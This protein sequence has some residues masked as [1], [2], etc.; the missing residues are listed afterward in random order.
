MLSEKKLIIK[1]LNNDS[2]AQK[3]LY[4]RYAPKMWGV[5]L[6]FAKNSMI[7]EDLLQEGFIKVYS[8]L[9]QYTHEGSFEG[10][11]RRT[12]INTAINYFKKNI[13]NTNNSNSSLRIQNQ[14]K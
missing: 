7:A 11:I 2:K 9:E 3:E 12:M 5:C 10:W 13:T 4:N 1:C 6:R 8:K 14:C